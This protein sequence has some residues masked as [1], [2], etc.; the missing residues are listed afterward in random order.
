MLNREEV[1]QSF[2]YKLYNHRRNRHLGRRIDL[3]ASAW[4]HAVDLHRRYYKLF[5]KG[6]P[7]AKLQSH[8]AKLR[9]TRRPEWLELNSQTLQE[10][11]DRLYKGWEAFFEKRAKRPPGF[12]ARRRYRSITFKQIGYK[13]LASGRLQIGEHTYRFWLSRPILGTVKTVTVKRTAL[14]EYFVSFSCS[15]VPAPKLMP[16]TG[17]TAGMDFG[18]KAFFTLN[19]GEVIDAPEPLRQEIGKARLLSRGLSKKARGSKARKKARLALAR[20]HERIANKRADWHHKAA[21]ALVRRFDAIAIEDLCFSG[22][23]KRWGRKMADLG[24]A[25]FIGILSSHA[26]KSGRTLTKNDRFMRST[27]VC[28]CWGSYRKLDLKE[29]EFECCRQLWQRDRAAAQIHLEAGR[30]LWTGA[31]VSP[32]I[33]VA[34]CEI[35]A[36]AGNTAESHAL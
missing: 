12:K 16:K 3:A 25:D 34:S 14:G 33:P 18:L 10:I 26:V 19:S 23:T 36:P 30:R 8:L 24:A 5:K 28:P 20:M 27:G 6:L 15:D 17:Q 13:L 35:P 7:K 32:Q 1:R 31:T 11:S 2:R 22:M 29:R 21:L 4:N 9:R